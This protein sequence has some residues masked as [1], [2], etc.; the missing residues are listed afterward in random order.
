MVDWRAHYD[1]I[2]TALG[3]AAVLTPIGTGIPVEDLTVIDKT[4]GVET[5]DGVTVSSIKPA[6]AM[7]YYELTAAGVT[8]A[9]LNGST[10]SFNGGSWIVRSTLPRPSP[11]G[12]PE[13]ELYLVLTE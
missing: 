11:A 12:E 5:G 6:A 9:Q 13:G 4:A 1:A 3:V 7:R 10:I 2:Y 8:R